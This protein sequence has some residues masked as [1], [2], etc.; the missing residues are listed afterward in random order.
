MG[1]WGAVYHRILALLAF[2]IKVFVGILQAVCTMI[3]GFH[4][5]CCRFFINYSTFVP[6]VRFDA[7]DHASSWIHGPFFLGFVGR[8]QLPQPDAFTFTRVPY[9]GHLAMN[10]LAFYYIN[11]QKHTWR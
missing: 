8:K 10:L 9:V 7:Y 4:C 1:G 6:L 3:V 2:A 11:R 5:T